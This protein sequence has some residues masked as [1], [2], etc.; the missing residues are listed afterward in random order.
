MAG[1][2]GDRLR[3]Q[4][5]KY[6]VGREAELNRLRDALHSDMPVA[7]IHGAA[8]V[9]KTTLLRQFSTAC[10]EGG[11]DTFAIDGREQEPTPSSFR[12]RYTHLIS[13]RAPGRCMLQIDN[14]EVLE[15]LDQWLRDSFLPEL[16]SDTFV[17]IASR[18]EPSTAWKTDPA[19]R[20]LVTE[21]RLDN[22]KPNE[23][24]SYLDKRQVPTSQHES[25]LAFTRGHPLA[26]SLLADVVGETGTEFRPE[27]SVDV[28]GA[29]VERFVEVVPTE[30]CRVA[31]EVCAL[32]RVTGEPLLAAS[33]K[34]ADSSEL[35]AW[36]RSLSFVESG[37]LGLQ[38]HDLARDAIALDLRWR[39]PDR[40]ALIHRLVREF[41]GRELSKA[42]G[43][44]QQAVL[45]DYIFLH[46]HS[47]AVS[48]FFHFDA[49][50]QGYADALNEQDIPALM[51]MAKVHEGDASAEWVRHWAREAPEAFLVIREVVQ[52][53]R[54]PTGFLVQ[55]DLGKHGRSEDPAVLACGRFLQARAPLKGAQRATLFRT[56]MSRDQYQ[57]ISPVQSLLFV[58]IVRHYLTTPN[59]AFTFLPCADPDLWAP[60]FAY[61]GTPR[62][63]EADFEIGG[64]R[65]GVYGHDFRSTTPDAWLQMLADREVPFASPR[66]EES[67]ERQ[68]FDA[69]VVDAL[70]SG[71]LPHRLKGNLL[72]DAKFVDRALTDGDSPELRARAL[73]TLFR[74]AALSLRATSADLKA[75]KA[76]KAGYFEPFATQEVAAEKLGLGVATFRRHLR[77]GERKVADFL[78]T[79]EH[80]GP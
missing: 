62:L 41:Y 32:A 1:N 12:D 71:F 21:V 47:P 3:V 10:V 42:S 49:A 70:K 35:F 27:Q 77:D 19:W 40:F 31:L 7:F 30:N 69:A 79:R 46:R 59:L 65:F 67:G 80:S 5:S 58:H 38:P 34:D 33:V 17:V 76:L 26:L 54:S 66:Q 78:W 55:I 52:G 16:P 18:R 6:F 25:V 2:L 23:C 20:G 43:I 74:E 13:G 22:L 50:V 15:P 9:G 11:V 4:R 39:N 36:L 56:W 57:S 29:L 37:S 73:Q 64:N 45:F 48:S 61:A 51:N 63:E 53:S 68:V 60:V 8:G 44:A 28:I 72:V 75:F 24:M 14:Y